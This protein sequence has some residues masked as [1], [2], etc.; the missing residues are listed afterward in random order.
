MDVISNRLIEH[1]ESGG[2]VAYPTSTLPGLGCLPTKNGLDSLFIIKNRS[3][4]HP[5]SLGVFS[6]E[7]A[8][9]LV[10]ISDFAKSLLED[11]PLGS[12]T[13]ILDAK[14]KLDPRL[15]GERV[16]IRVFANPT[17]RMLAKA[18]GPVTAT[19]ANPS[20]VEPSNVVSIAAKSLDL[21]NDYVLDGICPGG[22]GSTILSIEKNKSKNYGF[23]VSIMREGVVPQADVMAW[24]RKIR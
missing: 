14:Q 20:G 22:K 12:I 7:Q 6:L 4:K 15:G 13:L 17:A 2:V 23:S 5:V 1:L 16:A 19:S 11:F 3:E 24:M 21:N 10:E 9:D 18:V 8:E